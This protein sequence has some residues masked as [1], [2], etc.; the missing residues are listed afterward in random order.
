MAKK[1]TPLNLSAKARAEFIVYGD[2]H[3]QEKSDI[4]VLSQRLE[5]L[6]NVKSE[7]KQEEQQERHSRNQHN[8]NNGNNRNETTANS[9]AS[10][11]PDPTICCITSGANAPIT[12]PIKQA[13]LATKATQHR[14]AD[15][16]KY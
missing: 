7:A 5:K 8:G 15:E 13:R 6:I 14:Q 9:S 3:L 2:D 16:V 1:I 4:M 12:R 11:K 10:E